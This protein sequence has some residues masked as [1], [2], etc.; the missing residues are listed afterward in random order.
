MLCLLFSCVQE[1]PGDCD[2]KAVSLVTDWTA[3]GEG[4]AI[5]ATCTVRLGDYR[6]EVATGAPAVIDPP[7]A[8]GTYLV[9]AY[10]PA[11][12]ITVEGTTASVAASDGIVDALPGWFF[13]AAW[14]VTVEKER[15]QLLVAVMRQ[16]TRQLTLALE[17]AGDAAARVQGVTARLSG[18]AAA[19]DINSG[20]PVG[21]PAS[22]APVFEREPD[23]TCRAVARL[24]GVTG[25]GCTLTVTLDFAGGD[26][27]EL[28]PARDLLAGFNDDKRTPVALHA[29]LVVTSTGSGFSATIGEWTT[30]TGNAVA[31]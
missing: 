27:L 4:V 20:N 8:P 22:I 17:I 29:L 12:K 6:A 2:P 14:E 26:F 25:T 10:N 21:D 3:R 16:Q 30:G 18:V 13:T 1:R 28:T 31:D 24:L 11:G 23:G 19:I 5:P 9:N 7:P 15:D